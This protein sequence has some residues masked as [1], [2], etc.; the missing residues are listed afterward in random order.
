MLPDNADPRVL[1]S[2]NIWRMSLLCLS[3]LGATAPATAQSPGPFATFAAASA[4]VLNDPHDLTI[5]PDG[6]LYIADKFANRIVVM[7]P[8]SLEIVS[9]FA[10]GAVPGAHD[11]SFGPDG[12]AYVAATSASAVAV[13]NMATD[14]PS[15]IHALGPFPRTEGALAHSNGKLY[16]MASGLGQL[17]ALEGNQA[18]ASA[19]GMY[20]AH[21]VAEAPDGTLWVADT[22]ARQ[23]IQFTPDLERLKTLGGPDYAFAGPRYL[24]F[25]D[26]GRMIVADQDSHR[27][28]MINPESGALIGVLGDGTPGLGPGRFDDPEGVAVS[29][30]DYYFSDSDN[31]RI[32]KYIVVLN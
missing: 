12:H 20:G 29:G 11:I 18:V 4:P 19:I 28:L 26:F 8:E 6:R 13:Y 22:N 24:D 3:C 25:D 21:D 1:F 30:S 7:D 32:V 31:N 23:I 16:V 14:P 15:L 2:G 5:G 17:V 9:T 27:I 10:D